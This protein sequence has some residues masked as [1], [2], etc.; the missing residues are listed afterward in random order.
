MVLCAAINTLGNHTKCSSSHI[1]INLKLK[2]FPFSTKSF[3]RIHNIFSTV[4]HKIYI[5]FNNLL[6]NVPIKKIIL[7]SSSMHLFNSLHSCQF[8]FID[9]NEAIN[10]FIKWIKLEFILESISNQIF[11]PFNLHI[12]LKTNKQSVVLSSIKSK[13]KFQL[14]SLNSRHPQFWFKLRS[15]RSFFP[16][17]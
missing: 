10:H 9:F 15:S 17:K 16:Y 11:S 1:L 5:K 7:L 13:R 12:N 2:H 3:I 6:F 14:F 8:H 4:L